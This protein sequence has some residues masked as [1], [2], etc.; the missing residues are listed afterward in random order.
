VN[1][2]LLETPMA[3]QSRLLAFD[4][5][6]KNQIESVHYS[7]ANNVQDASAQAL[8]AKLKGSL[9]AAFERERKDAQP[10]A[11][12]YKVVATTPAH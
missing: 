4:N 2:A 11:H 1:L 8:A 3:L 5:D 10:V 12:R 6:R 9:D 7:Q